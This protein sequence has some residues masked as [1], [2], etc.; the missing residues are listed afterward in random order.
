M[1]RK[2]DNVISLYLD[3][4]RD[5]HVLPATDKFL[6]EGFVDHSSPRAPGRD[7]WVN[8][9]EPLVARYDDRAVWPLRGFEDGTKV[10]L[11]S[12]QTFGPELKWVSIDIFDTDDEDQI[13]ARWSARVPLASWSRSGRGQIDGPHFVDD[14]DCTEANT[15]LVGAYVAEVLINEEWDR[16][17]HYADVDLYAEHDPE[18]SDGAGPVRYLSDCAGAGRPVRFHR[19]QELLGCGNFVATLCTMTR[20]LT[21]YHAFDIYRVSHNRIV[22]HW[23]AQV[24]C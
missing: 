22:E 4:V 21:P 2:L 18:V 1:G 20:G 19:L 8:L 14:R 23:N 17:G 3:G 13:V 12:F 15:R 6:T 10:L 24:V 7:G 5:G 9:Y 11:H 16:F